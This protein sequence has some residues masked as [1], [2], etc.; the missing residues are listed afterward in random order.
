MKLQTLIEGEEAASEALRAY[1]QEGS[2]E[3]KLRLKVKEAKRIKLIEQIQL[4]EQEKKRLDSEL[5]RVSSEHAHLE[6]QWKTLMKKSNAALKESRQLRGQIG[7]TVAKAVN[8]GKE[9]ENLRKQL[10]KLQ[11][12]D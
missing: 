11:E 7:P 5:R 2:P 4:A 6:L 3:A 10:K 12:G 1:Q 9:I 8:A